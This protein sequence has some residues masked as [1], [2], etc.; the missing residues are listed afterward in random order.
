MPEHLTTY[1]IILINYRNSAVSRSPKTPMTVSEKAAVRHRHRADVHEP[2]A[3]K[4]HQH[5]GKVIE[6]YQPSIPAGS[7]AAYAPAPFIFLQLRRLSVNNLL[8]GYQTPAY[9]YI[10]PG[11]GIQLVVIVIPFNKTCTV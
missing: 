2:G 4:R 6:P 3:V 11:I 5:R 9:P 8:S 7:K 10:T 1:G